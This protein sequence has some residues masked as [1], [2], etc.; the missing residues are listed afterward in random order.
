M[1]QEQGDKDVQVRR[2]PL[3]LHNHDWLQRMLKWQ[4]SVTNQPT[5]NP[6]TY[7]RPR[8]L[9]CQMGKWHNATTPIS[10]RL[11]SQSYRKPR[12]SLVEAISVTIPILAKSGETCIEFLFWP[13]YLLVMPTCQSSSPSLIR[14]FS[15]SFSIHRIVLVVV[16][17]SSITL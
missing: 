16:S 15:P 9:V 3:S 11:R 7:H 12:C 14:Y 1:R 5:P 10:A 8:L 13:G 6:P 2:K 4:N 17:C